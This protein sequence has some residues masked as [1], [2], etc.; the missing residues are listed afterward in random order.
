MDATLPSPV[1]PS[2]LRARRYLLRRDFKWAARGF[3]RRFFE[4]IPFPAEAAQRLARLYKEGEVVHVMRSVGVLNFLYL[5]WALL[6]NGLPPLR[7]AI[8]LA[9][10]FGARSAGSCG[11]A[12]WTSG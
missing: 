5:A 8:G 1:E 3:A 10:S 6:Y 4:P 7:A 9:Y 11:A 2:T 12:R